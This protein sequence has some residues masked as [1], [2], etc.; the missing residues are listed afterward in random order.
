MHGVV[1]DFERH[2]EACPTGGLRLVAFLGGTIGNLAAGRA[3]ASS[4]RVRAARSRPGDTFLLGTDLVKDV[5]RLVAAYDDAAG[6]HR[7]VQPATCCTCSTGSSAPTSTPTASPTSPAGTPRRSGSR[8]GCGPAPP[9]GSRSPRSTWS[10]RS[11][12]VR[13]CAPR[14]SAKFRPDERSRGARSR[15]AAP[16][17]LLDRP[18]RRLRAHPRPRLRVVRAPPTTTNRRRGVG[19]RRRRRS[20][21]RGSGRCRSSRPGRPSRDAPAAPGSRGRGGARCC[22]PPARR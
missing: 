14:S 5:A 12:T 19:R 1:A 6:R 21:C 22:A 2:L 3:R 17:G 15:R 9:N 7:G 20:P 16:R 13:R 8:C 10:C 11:T 18:R 4:C